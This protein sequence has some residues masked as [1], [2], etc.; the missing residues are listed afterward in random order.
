MASIDESGEGARL[1]A[2]FL[3]RERLASV[4]RYLLDPD[5]ILSHYE[6][7]ASGY[8]LTPAGCEESFDDVTIAGPGLASVGDA[9]ELV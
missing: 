6:A 4:L 5:E 3:T 7:G 1:F 9:V 2:A 8:G